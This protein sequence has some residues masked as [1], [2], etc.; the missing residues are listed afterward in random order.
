MENLVRG[1]LMGIDPL[2][3]Q[4]MII[5]ETKDLLSRGQAEVMAQFSSEKD[6]LKVKE[7]QQLQLQL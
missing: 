6:R 2:R 7:K 3:I 1:Q 5:K 4:E